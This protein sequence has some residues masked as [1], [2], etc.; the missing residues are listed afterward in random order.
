MRIAML[1]W[2]FPPIIG[3]VESH[4]AMLCPELA[5]YGCHVSLLTGSTLE[6]EVDYTWRGL[7]ILRRRLMDLNSLDAKQIMDRKTIFAG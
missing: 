1:H 3:G 2:A 6:G 4:L 7:R 5:R